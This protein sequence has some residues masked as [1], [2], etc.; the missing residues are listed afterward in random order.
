MTGELA[1][2]GWIADDPCMWGEHTEAGLRLVQ[3]YQLQPNAMHR[4]I[5]EK[6]AMIQMTVIRL[7][8]LPSRVVCRSGGAGDSAGGVSG[9]FKA[10]ECKGAR[11]EGE[12]AG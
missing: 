6:P 12:S 4:Q 5:T 7:G 9:G 1:R 8:Y 11:V 10:A 3:R 2:C